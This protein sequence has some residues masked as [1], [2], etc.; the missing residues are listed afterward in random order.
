MRPVL[1]MNTA[2]FLFWQAPLQKKGNQQSA[3]QLP[4]EVEENGLKRTCAHTC[5]I[6][7]MGTSCL[8]PFP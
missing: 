7:A 5:E 2:E 6:P 1:L 8:Q 4:N 3:R